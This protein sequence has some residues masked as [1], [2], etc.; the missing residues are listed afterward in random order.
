MSDRL[1][2]IIAWVVISLFCFTPPAHAQSNSKGK[3]SSIVVG[4]LKE[5]NASGEKLKV[6]QAGE[7][8]R[9]LYT[10]S[11]SKVYFVGIVD[12][13]A[14]R[15]TIGYGVKAS[16]DKDGRI[17]MISFTPPIPEP[18]PLGEERLTMAPIEL[19]KRVDTDKNGR[20]GYGEFSQSVYHS[21]KHGPDH[22]RTADSNGDGGLS[23]AEFRKALGKIS[24]W[25]LSRK[26]PDVWFQEADADGDE[27]L[28]MKEFAQICTS[29]N[30]ID[31][32]FKRAD[33]DESGGLSLGETTTYIRSVTHGKQ[34]SR[35]PQNRDKRITTK[36]AS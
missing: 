23:S 9:E 6:L 30:H 19:F 1:N 36:S 17:K 27:T 8:L 5:V 14:R 24:W 13:A 21:P 15:A 20:V 22:F 35:K 25:T 7:L 34:K 16:C 33:L 3:N 2:H 4:I 18:K 11:K 10:D 29:G 12:E 28:T 26:A 32:V 31:N